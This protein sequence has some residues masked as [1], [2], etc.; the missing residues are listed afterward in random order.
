MNKPKFE[1]TVYPAHPGEPVKTSILL[2]FSNFEDIAKLY[3]C[4]QFSLL[5]IETGEYRHY[6][7]RSKN[8]A[9]FF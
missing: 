6:V 3:P 4:R 7:P 1:V 2:G 5:N 9:V 8:I